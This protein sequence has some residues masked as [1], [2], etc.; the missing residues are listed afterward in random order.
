MSLTLSP[1]TI[2]PGTSVSVSVSNPN[3]VIT[4]IISNKAYI[5]AVVTGIDNAGPRWLIA[6]T[7]DRFDADAG[8][9]NGSIGISGFNTANIPTTQ[10]SVVLI[11]VY[12]DGDVVPT[13]SWPVSIPSQVVNNSVAVTSSV[14]NDGNPAATQVVEATVT[15]SSGSNVVINNDGTGTISVLIAA[16][17]VQ[18]LK[19]AAADPVV[20]LGAATHLVEILGNLQVDGSITQSVGGQTA[21]Y[22][23]DS[24]G[25]LNIYSSG[26]SGSIQLGVNNVLGV[27]MAAFAGGITYLKSPTEIQFQVPQGTSTARITSGGFNI[28]NGSLKWKSGDTLSQTHAFNGTGTGTYAHGCVAAPFAVL[29]MTNVSGSQTMGFDSVT[30]TQVHITAFSGLNFTAVCFVG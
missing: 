1:V 12:Y 16:A 19:L 14:K 18:I 9:F 27:V 10:V 5:D 26:A 17:L 11:T 6:G 8:S 3:S 29:P 2:S 23:V 28:I 20:A 13:G 7:Q 25:N 21:T 4:I 15:G 30:A 24:S 22:S